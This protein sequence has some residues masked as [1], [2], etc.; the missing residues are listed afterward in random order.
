[1]GFKLF[2]G[3]ILVFGTISYLISDKTWLES[4]IYIP[5]LIYSIYG[6][7][8]GNAIRMDAPIQY[9]LRKAVHLRVLLF[10]S[11]VTI[12]FVGEKFEVLYLSFSIVVILLR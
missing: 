6:W 3:M 4:S 10:Y 9:W 2:G 5:L 8:S 7:F 1:M 11:C 12:Y